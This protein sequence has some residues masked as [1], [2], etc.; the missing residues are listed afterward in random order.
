MKKSDRAKDDAMRSEYDFAR[1]KGGVKGKYVARLAKGSNIVLLDPEIAA[2]FPSTESVNEALRGM[3]E[4]T[5]AV[6]RSG[7]LPNKALQPASRA[8]RRAKAQPRAGAARG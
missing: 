6:R 3:L 5:N 7:G 8:K 1:M 4:T 2:A